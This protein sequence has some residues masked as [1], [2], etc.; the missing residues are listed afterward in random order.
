MIPS[1]KKEG[2]QLEGPA[3]PHSSNQLQGAKHKKIVA[4]K[5]DENIK[6]RKYKQ[7]EKIL[8]E[9]LHWLSLA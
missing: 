7:N 4:K 3:A 2:T 1:H 8:T 5:K 6:V 9:H